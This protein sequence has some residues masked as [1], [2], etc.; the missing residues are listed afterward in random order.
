ME[1][2]QLRYDNRIVGEKRY[3]AVIHRLVK[4]CLS[5][6]FSSRIVVLLSVFLPLLFGTVT[7]V[8]AKI[9][10]PERNHMMIF[11]K[12]LTYDR[13]LEQDLA[14][15]VRIG[16]LYTP[17]NSA[18]EENRD[19]ALAALAEIAQKTINGRPFVIS[20]IEFR[21]PDQV[22]AA[23]EEEEI[24]VLYVTDGQEDKLA[25][26]ANMT[27]QR[28][29]LTLTG[30]PDYV[31]RWLSVSLTVRGETPRIMINLAACKA[32]QHEFKANLLR[33]CEV[34]R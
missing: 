4:V 2:R 6:R 22:A 7:G 5:Y 8:S 20:V 10:V 16:V 34:I 13:M 12:V 9:V 11:F 26:I 30:V 32:E 19:R 17:G 3:M 23:L 33:L 21:S 27:R 24:R 28:E 31:S 25:T 15:S 18:S 14:E 1:I 29:V